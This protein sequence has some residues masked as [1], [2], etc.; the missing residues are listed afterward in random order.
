MVAITVYSNRSHGRATRPERLSGSD[1]TK[2]NCC[3][4]DWEAG[5]NVRV[6]DLSDL[7]PEQIV[8]VCHN[9][10]I[11]PILKQTEWFIWGGGKL[12]ANYFQFQNK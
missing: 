10:E 2:C 4:V 1:N 6:P 3:K 7:S 11:P 8:N 12:K 5:F 9:Q